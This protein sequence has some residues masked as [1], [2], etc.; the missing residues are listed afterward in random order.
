MAGLSTQWAESFRVLVVL[1][2]PLAG[3]DLGLV[4]LLITY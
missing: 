1:H 2:Q 4:H 3:Q